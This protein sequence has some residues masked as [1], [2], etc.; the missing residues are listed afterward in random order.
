[1]SVPGIS[2]GASSPQA[3]ETEL[4]AAVLKKQ[5][6]VVKAKADGLVSLIQQA[7][8]EGVGGTINVYA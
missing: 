4:V 3:M 1:M 8:P 2:S 6:D 7:M 5:Q